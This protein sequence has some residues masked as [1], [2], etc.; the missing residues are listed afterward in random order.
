MI[1]R[2]KQDRERLEREV[3]QEKEKHRQT[4]NKHKT[5]ATKLKLDKDEVKSVIGL[6]MRKSVFQVNNQ[7]G[8]KLVCT[9]TQSE[10][11][12]P[13]PWNQTSDVHCASTLIT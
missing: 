4:H 11:P 6:N 10:L 7:M 9:A 2:L 8:L 3:A 5:M 13:I 1:R 12:R